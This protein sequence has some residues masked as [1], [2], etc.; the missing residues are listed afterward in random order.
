MKLFGEFV[1]GHDEGDI[2]ASLFS[3]KENKTV[4]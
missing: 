3:S 2:N 4:R 1:E